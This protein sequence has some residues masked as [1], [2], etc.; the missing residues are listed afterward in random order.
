RSGAESNCEAVTSK[1]KVESRA[2]YAQDDTQGATPSEKI[3]KGVRT[4]LFVLLFARLA[5]QG[6]GVLHLLGVLSGGNEPSLV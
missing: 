3:T 2:D 1:A 6:Y 5:P 4:V